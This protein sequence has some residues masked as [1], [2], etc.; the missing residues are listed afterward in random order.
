M[1]VALRTAEL[2]RARRLKVGAIIVRDDNIISFS[3]NG[4]PPGW[5]NNCE[6]ETESG[7][8]T[9]DE[10]IHAEMN[11]ILKLAKKGS[12][13]EGAALFLTHAPCITCA[14]CIYTAGIKSVYYNMQYR[15]SEGINFLEKCGV[16]VYHVN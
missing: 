5:D 13:A 2:S 3:W 9:K 6:H 14:K 15:S 10:V 11:A 7:L 1:D 8:V 4:T 16:N 12:S